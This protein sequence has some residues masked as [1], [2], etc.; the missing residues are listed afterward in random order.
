[1]NGEWKTA[2]QTEVHKTFLVVWAVKCSLVE[3]SATAL[4]GE[5]TRAFLLFLP[6]LRRKRR[7]MFGFGAK[8]VF[9]TKNSPNGEEK[10]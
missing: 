4:G 5:A 10:F 7:K 3:F 9:Y 2:R 8:V 6:K 1:M